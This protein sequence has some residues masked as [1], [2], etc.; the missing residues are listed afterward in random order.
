VLRTIRL[1]AAALIA[2]P[3]L[4]LTASLL[5]GSGWS[6]VIALQAFSP[7][8]VPAYA[9]ALALV[10]LPVG[11]R[12][13]RPVALS[14]AGLLVVALLV[15][16]AVVAPRWAGGAPAVAAGDA[17]L[18]V[19]TSNLRLGEADPAAVVRVVRAEKVD[20]LVLE[21]ITP[22]LQRRLEDVGLAELFPHRAGRSAPGAS[23]T[24]IYAREPITDAEE[25]ATEHGSWAV[26][27]QGL[28]IFGVH[29]AYPYSANWRS[30]Q[31]LLAAEATREHPDVVL[32]D[33]NAS[34]DN[35]S[36]RELLDTG[37]RDAAEETNAGWQPT[38]PTS[39]F[40][41]IPVPLAAIDHVLVGKSVVARSTRVHDIAG[42]DHR[43]L[44]AELTVV[45]G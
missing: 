24:L 27:V 8:A 1:I 6:T 5:I 2:L 15:S 29:P 12:I 10:L 35:P 21:E 40:R 38:W 19:M 43:A 45:G 7:L 37:L 4:V 11:G 39:G 13:A 33:H 30:D 3:A 25:I 44:V 42:T 28:R 16:T 34:L 18:V 31:V 14:A 23:G 41:G 17:R 26:T 36:F 22:R 20:I 32:G 9:I